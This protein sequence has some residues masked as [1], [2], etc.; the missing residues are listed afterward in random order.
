[1]KLSDFDTLAE[2]KSA[3]A[4]RGKLIHRNSM[5]A[6]LSEADRYTRLKDIAADPT[7]PLQ[8]KVAAFMDSTEFNFMQDNETGLKVTAM[9]DELITHENDPALQAVRDMSVAKA[10]ESYKP[11]ENATQ[12]DWLKAKGTCPTKPV[13]AINGWVKIFLTRDVEAHAPQVYGM[14]QEVKTRVAGFSTISK[15]GDYVVQVPRGFR[16]MYVDDAYEAIE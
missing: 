15:A 10:N 3:T 16:Q 14:V 7:H 5:N 9:M 4:V 6:M 11:F 1:M 13:T 12:Y 2:A 8:D